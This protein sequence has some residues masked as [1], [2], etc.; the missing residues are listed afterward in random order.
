MPSDSPTRLYFKLRCKTV[1]NTWMCKNVSMISPAFQAST[2]ER[3]VFDMNSLPHENGKTN[4]SCLT[5]VH[6]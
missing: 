2:E 1:L 4:I 3:I 5:Y 6:F